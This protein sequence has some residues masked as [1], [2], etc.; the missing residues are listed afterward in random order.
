[1]DTTIKKN[2]E[3]KKEDVG[4]NILWLSVSE[5]AKIGGV[6]TKTI[7]RAIQS[8]VIKYKIKGNRYFINFLSL[9]SYL[10]SKIKLKNKFN[11]YGLG[12]YIEKW[13]EEK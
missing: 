12:R 1:M 4:E 6:Q 2:L 8:N 11:L 13:K 7:R 10:N 5:S 9:I 3:T